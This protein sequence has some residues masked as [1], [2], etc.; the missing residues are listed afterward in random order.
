MA[1]KKVSLFALAFL[2]LTGCSS[3]A[4]VR[5]PEARTKSTPAYE[6]KAPF[7]FFGII[8]GPADVYADRICLKQQVDQVVTEYTG[9]DFAA[10]LFTLGIY[11]PRTVKVWCA[12]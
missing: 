6:A 7:F 11:S 5:V 4:F 8:G 10:T 1:S 9:G 3:V 12:L 2:T